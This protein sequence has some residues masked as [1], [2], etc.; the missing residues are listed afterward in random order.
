MDGDKPGDGDCWFAGRPG[1][2]R[3]GDAQLDG[4]HRDDLQ[5][6]AYE[7]VLERDECAFLQMASP[8]GADYGD[9]VC[10]V[11]IEC[12][13]IGIDVHSDGKQCGG[14]ASV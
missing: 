14:Y 11:W 5:R 7:R 13:D 1:R 9:G 3:D 2:F 10:G 6:D 8:A 4:G 12:F